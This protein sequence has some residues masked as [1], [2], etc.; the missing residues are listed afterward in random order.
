MNIRRRSGRLSRR[1][2]WRYAQRRETIADFTALCGSGKL[3]ST[4]SL[5]SFRITGIG[6]DFGAPFF[7]EAFFATGA[8]VVGL[9]DAVTGFAAVGRPADDFTGSAGFTVAFGLAT[10]TKLA[11]RNHSSGKIS[12]E[13][14]PP[15]SARVWLSVWKS[16]RVSPSPRIS[17]PGLLLIATQRR[18][19]P[20]QGPKPRQPTAESST[21]RFSPGQI[22]LE[23]M[24]IKNN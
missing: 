16:P 10:G 12:P 8:D 15:F 13:P 9:R 5:E 19:P 7:P 11:Q 21:V 14:S 4:Y 17:G 1:R 22:N 18:F 2:I 3:M 6:S 24:I 23:S 20:G